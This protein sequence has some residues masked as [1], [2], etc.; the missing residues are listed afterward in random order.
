MS[1]TDKFKGETDMERFIGRRLA[2]LIAR[3]AAAGKAYFPEKPD[4]EAQSYFSPYAGARGTSKAETMIE[5]FD[6]ESLEHAL[7][8]LWKEQ[9]CDELAGLAHE[10]GRLSLKLKDRGQEKQDVS[11]FIYEMF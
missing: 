7:R 8:T 5:V 10:I 1:L 9:G 6:P 4:A 2:P 3:L 11:P